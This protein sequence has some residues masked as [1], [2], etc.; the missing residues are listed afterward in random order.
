MRTA[1]SAIR[2]NRGLSQRQLSEI[3]GISSQF[4]S[5]IETGVQ[6]G[7]FELMVSIARE[8]HA[9]LDYLA[10]G[11]EPLLDSGKNNMRSNLRCAI[12]LLLSIEDKMADG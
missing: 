7:S 6:M 3:L 8:L 5:R 9:S 2:R 12:N 10:F 4:L 11:D 1:N